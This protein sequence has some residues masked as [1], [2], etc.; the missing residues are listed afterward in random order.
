MGQAARLKRERELGRR[1]AETFDRERFVEAHKRLQAWA[2]ARI[3][4][5]AV[6]RPN[7]PETRELVRQRA[8]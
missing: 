2:P 5:V 1:I 3:Y 6:G 7:N 8:I 4:P